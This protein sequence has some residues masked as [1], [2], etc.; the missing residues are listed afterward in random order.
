MNARLPQIPLRLNATL[1]EAVRLGE[2]SIAM[3]VVRLSPIFSRARA[4]AIGVAFRLARTTADFRLLHEFTDPGSRMEHRVVRKWAHTAKTGRELV[5]VLS[6]VR[7]LEKSERLERY[8]LRK[9]KPL[10]YRDWWKP[11]LDNLRAVRRLLR[12][13]LHSRKLA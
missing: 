8:L 9:L 10:G 13:L 11:I 5:E 3:E 7:G 2:M 4:K 1:R 12:P 6:I